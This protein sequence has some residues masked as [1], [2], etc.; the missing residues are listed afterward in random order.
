MQSFR[1][2][3]C[4]EIY[5]RPPLIGKCTQKGCGGKIIFTIAEGSVKKYLIPSIDLAKKYN[6]PPYLQQ[7]LDLL[8][9]RIDS[10][11]GIDSEKQ[12]G[13]NKWFC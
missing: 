9:T 13:L 3:K 1:C 8:K 4:N 12:E 5:R 11:F 7:T 2:V 6:L 10:V